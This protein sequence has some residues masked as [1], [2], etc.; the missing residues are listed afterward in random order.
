MPTRYVPILYIEFQRK[1][2]T[3]SRLVLVAQPLETV[4]NE[5]KPTAPIFV[6]LES[7]K[8]SKKIK[9]CDEIKKNWFEWSMD[10]PIDLGKRRKELLSLGHKPRTSKVAS[11]KG[12]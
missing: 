6:S 7:F 1:H 10:L 8:R 5:K 2:Q 11:E 3:S 9:Q 12:A 4:R